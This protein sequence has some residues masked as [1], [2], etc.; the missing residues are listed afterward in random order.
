VPPLDLQVLNAR[1]SLFVTRP[2][3][4]DYIATRAELLERAEAVL[5]GVARGGLRIRIHTEFPLAR[6]AEAH[7]AL[8]SRAT[9]G[10]LLLVAE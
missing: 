5:G 1:G 4:G 2:K 10:K 3:L 8:E 6:A 7:R 9:S